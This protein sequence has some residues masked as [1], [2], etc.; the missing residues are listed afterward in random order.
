MGG[1]FALYITSII[2]MLFNIVLIVGDR[3]SIMFAKKCLLCN[4]L[5]IIYM[6]ILQFIICDEN[7]WRTNSVLYLKVFRKQVY[8]LVRT[9]ISR[10]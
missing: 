8:R 10:I 9:Y 5:Y 6:C 2:M 1:N 4:I 7:G 3:C